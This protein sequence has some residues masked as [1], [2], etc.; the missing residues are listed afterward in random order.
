ML[1]LNR[2]KRADS[3]SLTISIL[4]CYSVKKKKKKFF[5]PLPHTYVQLVLF[6]VLS[7]ER[8]PA[9]VSWHALRPRKQSRRGVEESEDA[10]RNILPYTVH[11]PEH[12]WYASRVS[13]HIK[14][15]FVRH[16]VFLAG[17]EKRKSSPHVAYLNHILYRRVHVRIENHV[18]VGG[19]PWSNYMRTINN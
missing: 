6:I 5:V 19:N 13:Q 3:H 12:S 9:H 17:H 7:G 4:N 14:S 15:P 18:A 11:G 10:V 8:C 1:M 2:Q 16:F